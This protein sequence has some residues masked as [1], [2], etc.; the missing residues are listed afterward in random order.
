MGVLRSIIA[1][2]RNDMLYDAHRDALKCMLEDLERTN[3]HRVQEAAVLC[4]VMSGMTGV[5]LHEE[6]E[7]GDMK[8]SRAVISDIMTHL[9]HLCVVEDY[10][11][12]NI[13]Q[14]A[15]AN[16]YDELREEE[17]DA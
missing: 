16:L 7:N 13:W 1:K 10:D 11:T 15:N 3:D 17:G 8:I 14:I 5:D 9:L 12:V 4:K 2:A 6:D